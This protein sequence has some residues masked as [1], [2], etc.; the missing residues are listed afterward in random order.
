MADLC[1]ALAKYNWE[2][3]HAS[4]ES[5]DG[6]DDICIHMN[7][8]T[9]DAETVCRVAANRL[10]LLANAFDILATMDDPCKPATHD[11]ALAAAKQSRRESLRG[12]H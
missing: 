2:G 7:E 5:E 12:T 11:A 4:I 8:C 6:M 3:L 1:I 9:E 10:R